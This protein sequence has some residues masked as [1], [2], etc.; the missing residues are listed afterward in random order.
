MYSKWI[1]TY[2]HLISSI[3]RENSLRIKNLSSIQATFLSPFVFCSRNIK[4]S[5]EAARISAAKRW[6][7]WIKV[8]N[9]LIEIVRYF[10]E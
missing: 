7:G 3:I 4:S 8:Y 9:S 5:P 6:L 1:K 2:I 10:R